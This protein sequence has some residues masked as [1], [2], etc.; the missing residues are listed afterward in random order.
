[1]SIPIT[2]SNMSK[3]NFV[4]ALSP[5]L[6]SRYGPP[7]FEKHELD[8]HLREDALSWVNDEVRNHVVA[9]IVEFP[10][11]SYF[12]SSS[13]QIANS[14]FDRLES[15]S[16]ISLQQILYISFDFG[17]SFAVNT[18]LFFRIGGRMLNPAVRAPIYT[19]MICTEAI[20][21]TFGLLTGGIPWI[22]DFLLIPVQLTRELLLVSGLFPRDLNVQ[23]NLGS[24]TSL[25]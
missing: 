22:K 11:L 6:L 8:A 24:G 5:P 17:A 1:M 3:E 23:T 25:R 7:A 15:D 9:M 19:Q 18:W 12:S 13:V 14:K 16:T 10:D 20:Q 4:N 2:C 21:V